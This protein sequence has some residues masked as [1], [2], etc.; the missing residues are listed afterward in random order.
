VFGD[1]PRNATLITAK[2][3]PDRR[4]HLVVRVGQTTTVIYDQK[5]LTDYRTAWAQALN[6]AQRIF[7]NPNP[8]AFDELENRIRKQEH[9]HFEQTGSL[10]KSR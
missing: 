10:P 3:S 9:R 8:D 1:Q 7:T 5:A 4:P 2:A 6:Y